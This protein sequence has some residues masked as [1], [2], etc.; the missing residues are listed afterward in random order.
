MGAEHAME[1]PA[2]QCEIG[3][4]SVR[5]CRRLQTE[6]MRMRFDF[7]DLRLI[8]AVAECCSITAGARRAHLSLPA[9]SARIRSLETALDV[10]LLERR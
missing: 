2:A 1:S 3:E 9:A 8:V 4:P 10:P 7:Q 6:A 5:L